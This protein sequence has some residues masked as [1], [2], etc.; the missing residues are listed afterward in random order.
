MDFKI[1]LVLVGILAGA[2]ALG[3]LSS[4]GALP[5]IESAQVISP[6]P[7]VRAV[8][9]PAQIPA[10][11]GEVPGRVLFS[12]PNGD[13]VKA[14]FSVV[15]AVAFQGFDLDLSGASGI[16]SGSFS[17]ILQSSLAQV[18]VLEVI[19]VDSSGNESNPFEFSFEAVQQN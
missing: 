19:L 5:R 9:F 10:T 11:G 6:N 17:F 15:D 2:L 13:I 16:E 4:G 7:V 1:I 12:D 14:N 3:W 18:V 8:E